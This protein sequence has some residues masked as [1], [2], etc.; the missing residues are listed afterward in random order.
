MKTLRLVLPVVILV[1]LAAGYLASQYF[2][3]QGEPQKWTQIIDRPEIAWLALAI[4]L[5]A[6]ALSF[7]QDRSDE[8]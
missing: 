8:T 1:L 7:I 6:I 3:F 2:W 4:L 5:G